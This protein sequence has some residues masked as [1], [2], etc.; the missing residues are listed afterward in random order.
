MA[1][2]VYG[3]TVADVADQFPDPN[4]E[5]F[6]AAGGHGV[7]R[8]QVTAWIESV[9]GEVNSLICARLGIEPE[10]LEETL[11][12][13]D[14][15]A[16]ADAIVAKVIARSLRKLQ[17]FDDA[18]AFSAEYD[19]FWQQWQERDGDKVSQD[20]SAWTRTIITSRRNPVWGDGHRW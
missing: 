4:A 1:I 17:R 5:P 20:G 14:R 18:Q 11:T 19:R 16:A 3:L 9:S 2:Y 15:A 13:E 8:T 6:G 10:D 12:E 7:T